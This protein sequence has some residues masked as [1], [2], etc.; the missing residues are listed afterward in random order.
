MPLRKR[1]ARANLAAEMTS[2]STSQ[3]MV[4]VTSGIATKLLVPMGDGVSV[5]V[6]RVDRPDKTIVCYSTQVGCSVGCGFCASGKGGFRRNLN[7][8]EMSAI[9]DAAL[10]LRDRDAPILLSAMGEGEPTQNPVEVAQVMR[11]YRGPGIRHAVST[12]GPSAR[13]VERFLSYLED[14]GGPVKVQYSLHSAIP[15]VRRM[16][17]PGS[18]AEPSEILRLLSAWQDVELNVVLWDGVND[19]A[20]E[21]N[22]MADLLDAH[23]TSRP[24][25][26][27][28]NRGNAIG[29]SLRPA[30]PD[31]VAAW[32]GTLIRRGHSVEAYATDGADIEAACGQL[33]WKN[34]AA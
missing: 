1:N 27:K 3:G 22:R 5:E 14:C 21:A 23:R 19:T 11:A 31:G 29:D 6:T 25:R 7:A 28:L 16:L 12:S 34:Q 26:L 13:L 24:W 15:T 10:L 2:A 32:A 17:M 8:T 9:V 18:L 33:R 20:A 4:S 30:R